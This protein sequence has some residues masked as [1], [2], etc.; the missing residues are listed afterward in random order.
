MA[1][2][3]AGQKRQDFRHFRISSSKF[4]SSGSK[5]ISRN[6]WFQLWFQLGFHLHGSCLICHCWHWNPGPAPMPFSSRGASES[7]TPLDAFRFGATPASVALSPPWSALL[8]SLV[9][10]LALAFGTMAFSTV[11]A[12]LASLAAASLASLAT[13]SLATLQG[14]VLVGVTLLWSSSFCLTGVIMSSND[15]KE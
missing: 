15:L 6:L 5:C 12:P 2:R 11:C 7:A 4:G 8:V 3:E 14:D 10:A 9:A 1:H 13:A